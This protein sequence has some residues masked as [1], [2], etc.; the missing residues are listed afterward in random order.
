MR[1]PYAAEE[2]SLNDPARNGAKPR[3]PG[4]PAGRTHA[5]GVIADRTT[6]LEAAERLITREGPAVSLDA[7][8]FEAGVTKPILYRGVGDRDALVNALAGRLSERL[9]E[10]VRRDVAAAKSAHDAVNRLV[11]GY[12]RHAQQEKN[13]YLY[14][15]GGGSAEDRIHDL[16]RLAD[17]SA[18][19]F[20]EGIAQYRSARGINDEVATTWSYG[21]VGAL[22]YVTLHMLRQDN[23][24]A[25][26][27]AQELTQLLW[28]GFSLE[29][30]E[31][32]WRR[33]E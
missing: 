3:R 15:S 10:W 5:D 25:G 2:N 33:P 8:A 22:H 12:L 18:R 21:L 24:D 4:R 7:I 13:L 16:L 6:L 28:T 30:D 32:P 26:T 27:I 9:T 14:V 29:T 20:A 19:L 1:S 23:A 11:G 31:G 17:M